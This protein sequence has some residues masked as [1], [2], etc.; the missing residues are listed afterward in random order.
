MGVCAVVSGDRAQ[1]GRRRH[2]GGWPV[3]GNVA[4]VAV[5]ELRCGYGPV[6]LQGEAI[7]GGI[8]DGIQPVV[9]LVQSDVARGRAQEHSLPSGDEL[10][11][12][13]AAVGRLV[14]ARRDL[15]R[16]RGDRRRSPSAM[17]IAR[18]A[19]VTGAAA[20]PFCSTTAATPASVSACR[21]ER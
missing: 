9:P 13:A 4:A 19:R 5:P 15:T 11:R 17:P 7:P 14:A 12:V 16:V 6:D 8:C 21:A 1:R 3:R 2:A 18:R 20:G 10:D